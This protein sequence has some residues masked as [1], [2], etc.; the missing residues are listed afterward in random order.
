MKVI[1]VNIDPNGIH[2]S[3]KETCRCGRR[4]SVVD[5]Q[6][7]SNSA[8]IFLTAYHWTY[9]LTWLN[10]SPVS[11]P[12][13]PRK[14]PSKAAHV[15]SRT[16]P[17][18]LNRLL[19]IHNSI[20]QAIS[21]TL[22]TSSLIITPSSGKE[23]SMPNP[24]GKITSGYMASVIN[25][26]GF[27]DSGASRRCSVDDLS[28][29]VW[30]WEWDEAELPTKALRSHEAVN[31]DPFVETPKDWLRGGTG[32]IVSQTTHLSRSISKRVP[33]YGIG[34]WIDS[35]AKGMA[36]I[37]Q[38]TG[39]APKRRKQLTERLNKWVDFHTKERVKER[40]TS[41]ASSP[42]PSPIPNI[43]FAALPRL[44]FSNVPS[45][46]TS[47]RARSLLD[48]PS[49]RP[50]LLRSPLKKPFPS[51]SIPFPAT[52]S[53]SA[54][55][56]ST[57][58]HSRPTSPIKGPQ[59]GD[60]PFTRPVTPDTPRQNNAAMPQTPSTSSRRQA[61][62]E[63]IRLKSLSAT[64]KKAEGSVQIVQKGVDGVEVERT[65]GPEEVRR[66]LLLGR[67]PGVAEAIWMCVDFLLIHA[68][69]TAG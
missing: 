52:P 30:L 29:L 50:S 58:V 61:L 59:F 49:S 57:P 16:L 55:S 47:A 38:W 67:L 3:S 21:V 64:P 60:D 25:H 41:R 2:F 54:S 44:P 7:S 20:E 12:I 39:G 31:D 65:I 17:S 28:R 56:S 27:A 4:R 18:H 33:A 5:P 19:E 37:G 6:E 9:L 35:T 1:R 66:R 45:T 62:L 34:V 24:D 40:E 69:S 15:S 42:T 48:T 8:S 36:A 53:S 51:S 22:A 32:I 46:P 13:T 68:T 23:R 11:P 10:S 14:S 63:R 26:V 43:P